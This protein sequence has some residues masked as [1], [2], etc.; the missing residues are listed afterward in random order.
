MAIWEPCNYVSNLAY[1][2]LAVEPVRISTAG[3]PLHGIQNRRAG[4]PQNRSQEEDG[5]KKGGA[6]RKGGG[7][8]ERTKLTKKGSQMASDTGYLCCRGL[9]PLR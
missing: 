7:R 1:D 2:R 4:I 8:E 9:P 5:A 3:I 6:R